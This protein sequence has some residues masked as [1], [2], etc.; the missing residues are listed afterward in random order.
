MHHS[1]RG[2]VPLSLFAYK[3]ASCPL[4]RGDVVDCSRTRPHYASRTFLVRGICLDWVENNML[5][6]TLHLVALNQVLFYSFYLF[7]HSQIVP[8]ICESITNS[9]PFLESK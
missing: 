7:C 6:E 2:G 8:L 9:I 1:I 4:L 5:D 3:I